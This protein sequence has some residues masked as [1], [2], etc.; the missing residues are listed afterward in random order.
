MK[1]AFCTISTYSHLYKSLA[2]AQSVQAH[3]PDVA[4]NLL[5]TDRTH[6]SPNEIDVPNIKVYTLAKMLHLPMAKEIMTRYKNKPDR[7]RWSLKPILLQ[8]LLTKEKYDTVVYGDNDLYFYQPF[9]FLFNDLKTHAI[10][11]NP[12]WRIYEV[13]QIGWLECNF[14]EGLYNAGFIGV[15]QQAI[16]TLQ[17]WA[18]AC[19]HECKRRPK[20]G[21]FD[22]Q[23]YLDLVPIIEPTAKIIRHQGCNVAYWNITECKRTLVNKDILINEK[24]PIIFIHFALTTLQAIQEKEDPLL[25][26]FLEEYLAA[27]KKRNPK[28]T[29]PTR[30]KKTWYYQYYER[31]RWS[32]NKRMKKYF[33][34]TKKVALLFLR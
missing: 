32:F 20:R 16:P 21:L 34:F 17:W 1:K 8:Y 11:L 31:V 27:L 26:S 10:L 30:P 5:I 29:I 7:L 24:Y 22:D 18:K 23:K 25:I 14:K 15:N 3:Q 13:A 6:L 33:F 2:L 19:E 4:F 9:N 12:H 28:F